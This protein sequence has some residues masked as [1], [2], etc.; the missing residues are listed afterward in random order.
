MTWRKSS[1]GYLPQTA[2]GATHKECINFEEGRCL[3]H[4]IPVNPDGTDICPS[5][6]QREKITTTESQQG[7]FSEMNK[8]FQVEMLK[9]RKK[10]IETQLAY[11]NKKIKKITEK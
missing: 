3:L 11:L 9:L 10:M 5:F 2:K 6:T 1:F 8:E 4:N 7:K